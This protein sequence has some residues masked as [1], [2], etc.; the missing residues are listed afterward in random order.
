MGY[1][2]NNYDKRNIFK[3]Q[4]PEDVL[5]DKTSTLQPEP[6]GTTYYAQR[7]HLRS[8]IPFAD[9]FVSSFDSQINPSILPG[10]LQGFESA[11]VIEGYYAIE[12]GSTYF[13]IEGGSTYFD[14]A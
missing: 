8:A 2:N 10:E 7:R 3:K 9:R 14:P 12:G 1:S 6:T 11:V 5:N 13:D 4:K